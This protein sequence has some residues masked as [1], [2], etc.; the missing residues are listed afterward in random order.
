MAC[1]L[2]SGIGRPACPGETPGCHDTF[3]LF[4]RSQVTAF[5]AGTGNIVANITFASGAGYYQVVAKKGSVVGRNELQD[6][7]FSSANWTLEVDFHLADLSS[8]ARDFVN[9]LA[10][11]ELGVIIK[12]KGDKFL[13]FGYNDGLE[14]KVNNMTTEAEGLGEFVTLRS[15]EQNEKHRIFFDTN[16]TTTEANITSKIVGS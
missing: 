13:L 16:T 4:N 10:G 5:V 7:E 11:P 1:N 12:T 2:T 6:D 9:D 14:M 3:Y 8:E 15:I